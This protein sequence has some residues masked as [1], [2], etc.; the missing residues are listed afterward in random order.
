MTRSAYEF[1]KDV[2]HGRRSKNDAL[3]HLEV[4]SGMNRGSASDYILNFKKMMD[5]EKY[6]RTNNAEQTEYFFTQI[7]NDYGPDRLRNALKATKEHVDYYEGLR[8]VNLNAIR[9]IIVRHE[10]LLI[11]KSEKIYSEEIEDVETLIEGIKK[12]VIVNSF[13]RN[14]VVRAKCIKHYGVKCAACEFDFEVV[15]GEIG[16]DFIH[17]HHL[18]PLSEIREG[19]EVDPISDLRPVC[20]N[21]HAMLHRRNPPFTIDELKQKIH[22]TGS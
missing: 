21:C 18:T 19:Y 22:N 2:Y 9:A 7:F 8:G 3:D 12:T 5:G 1:A 16:R 15:Y 6:T 13:E 14:Q 17:V 4:D 20:P 10:K 11:S